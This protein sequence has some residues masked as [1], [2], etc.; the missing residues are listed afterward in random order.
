V[1][2]DDKKVEIFL[3]MSDEYANINVDVECC[4]DEYGSADACSN[5]NPFQN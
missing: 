3:P 2:E 1:I 4:C 5:D